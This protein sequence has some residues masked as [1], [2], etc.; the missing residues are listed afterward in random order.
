MKRLRVGRSQIKD[1]IWILIIAMIVFT[2]VGFHLRVQL[3]RL[4]SFAPQST[5]VEER[6]VLRDFD[7]YLKD[8]A[9]NQLAMESVRG[10]VIVINFW[11]TW[12]PPCVAEMPSLNAL[13]KD[14]KDEVVFLF[15]AQDDSEKVITYLEK[16]G[17]DFPV[18]FELNAPPNLLQNA[19]IPTTYILSKKGEIV[20]EKTG[21][22]D[23]NSNSTRSLLSE[24]LQG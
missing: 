2:P 11:A 10:K 18:Y 14:Y 12:C 9:G 21:A 17:Y 5:S 15:V 6:T 20:I 4:L 24:L 7:W 23:W 1:V 22:A 16:Q 3:T 8:V 19:S 13:Y